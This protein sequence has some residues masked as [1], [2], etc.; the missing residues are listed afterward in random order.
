[1]LGER[2][3]KC[4]RITHVRFSSA[5]RHG[6]FAFFQDSGNVEVG[7]MG[8]SLFVQYHIL[9]FH[10]PKRQNNLFIADRIKSFKSLI[11]TGNSILIARS[12]AIKTTEML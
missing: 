6:H 9:R 7:Q 4:Q 2:C 10:V 11:E 1:M 8:V 3:N 12:V 5:D